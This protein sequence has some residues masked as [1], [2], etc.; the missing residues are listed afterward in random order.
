[1]EI[2]YTAYPADHTAHAGATRLC[3]QV[4]PIDGGWW[5]AAGAIRVDHAARAVSS[6]VYD[7][8]TPVRRPRGVKSLTI[9]RMAISTLASSHIH[10]HIYSISWSVIM[11]PSTTRLSQTFHTAEERSNEAWRTPT[12]SGR[13][14]E[15]CVVTH[16]TKTNITHN[17]MIEG[18]PV[19][20]SARDLR[21]VHQ[22][23]MCSA[24]R[25]KV[26]RR[27]RRRRPPPRR[28]PR[29]LP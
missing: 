5:R 27:V 21:P 24:P 4:A 23:H 11:P 19:T 26:F 25:P 20:R 16:N 8:T 2:E 29:P 13:H 10:T 18:A 14:W 15:L 7:D 3:C 28:M 22:W 17:K 9:Y 12:Y 1:M 6:P